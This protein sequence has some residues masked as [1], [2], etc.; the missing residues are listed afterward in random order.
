LA[1]PSWLQDSEGLESRCRA[2]VEE[3]RWPEGVSCLRCSSSRV[4]RLVTRQK[5]GCRRC[6]YQFSVTTGTAMHNSH[7]PVWKWFLAIEL[8]LGSRRGIPANRLTRVLGGSYKTAWFVEHR[9]RA[10][11]RRA[12]RGDR[13][14]A[15]AHGALGDVR[16]YDRSTVGPYHQIGFRYLA[17]YLT[18]GRWRAEN[19]ANPTAFRDTVL[20]LIEA[21]P[22]AYDELIGAAPAASRA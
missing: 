10:S 5:F 4:G 1:D 18:E 11:L 6:G 14:G 13:D 7:L 16:L 21:E 20:A 3:L 8:M 9:V 2:Y 17:G 12:R 22:L 15:L 19:R